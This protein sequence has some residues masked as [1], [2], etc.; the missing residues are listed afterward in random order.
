MTAAERIL[1]MLY[2]APTTRADLMYR[3]KLPKGTIGAA[4]FDL[5][6]KGKIVKAQDGMLHAY[7]DGSRVYNAWPEW[8]DPKSDWVRTYK[9]EPEQVRYNRMRG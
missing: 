8:P 9:P 1:E 5:H 6:S 3:I 4:L 2:K 7:V